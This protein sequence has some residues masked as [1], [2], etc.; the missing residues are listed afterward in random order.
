MEI[1]ECHRAPRALNSLA[2]VRKECAINFSQVI[3]IREPRVALVALNPN[4][5][6]RWASQENKI[7]VAA[8]LEVCVFDVVVGKQQRVSRFDVGHA[9]EP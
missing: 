3:Q 7:F 8:A 2:C 6:T 5:T 4:V 1:R 9:R